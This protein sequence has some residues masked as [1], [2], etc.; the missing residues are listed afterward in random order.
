MMANKRM[1]VF[2]LL[3]VMLLGLVISGCA[4]EQPTEPTETEP[5]LNTVAFHEL[6]NMNNISKIFITTSTDEVMCIL[7]DQEM[8][9]KFQTTFEDLKLRKIT[10]IASSTSSVA[11]CMT[12]EYTECKEHIETA[13]RVE[14]Q[15]TD[16]TKL[17]FYI[18][19]NDLVYYIDPLNDYY[20]SA[21]S[22]G[23]IDEILE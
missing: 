16:D 13:Y 3:G 20:V 23:Y 6:V 11:V 22:T 12:D 4:P 21:G 5:D 9:S 14:V 1:K 8:V 18:G 2:L 10:K 7:E 15:L 17:Y 19:T